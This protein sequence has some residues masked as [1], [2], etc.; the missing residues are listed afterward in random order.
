MVFNF[1]RQVSLSAYASSAQTFGNCSALATTVGGI[2]SSG[3]G[4]G[5]GDY[6]RVSRGTGHGGRD[7]EVGGRG[8]G[9]GGRDFGVSGCDPRKCT[10]C[11]L[12][13][14]TVDYRWDLHGCLIALQVV[15]FS[16]EDAS[17]VT[18]PSTA[19][20]VVSIP[21]EEYHWGIDTTV[22][23]RPTLLPLLL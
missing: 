20:Q 8:T 15:R 14:Y 1:L 4:H 5:C 19:N 22:S 2:W 21:K 13:N 12:E 16:E 9:C 11:G 17:L 7:S 6:G 23:Y 10:D 18:L 3:G